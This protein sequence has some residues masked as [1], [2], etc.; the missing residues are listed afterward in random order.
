VKNKK[1]AFD[2]TKA[3]RIFYFLLQE[4]QIK[5]SSNHVI[6]RVDELKKI[7]YCK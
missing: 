4:G 2:I 3:D 6:P 5:L 7:K 1:F